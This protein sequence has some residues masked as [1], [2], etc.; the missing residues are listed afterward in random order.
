MIQM[1]SEDGRLKPKIYEFIVDDADELEELPTNVGVGSTAKCIENSK[2]YMLNS[3]GEWIEVNFKQ[4]SGGGGG[5]SAEIFITNMV[6]NEDF[7]V[8][9]LDKTFNEIIEAMNSGLTPFVKFSMPAL[10][11]A[12]S[13]PIIQALNN[14]GNCE[15]NVLMISSVT[16]DI[17][18]FTSDSGDGTLTW[19]V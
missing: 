16:P 11:M 17:V 5:G 4:G 3:S 19:S 8:A 18:T 14:M 9:S 15:V 12:M 6:Y 13:C 7:T 1:I 10:D 2:I